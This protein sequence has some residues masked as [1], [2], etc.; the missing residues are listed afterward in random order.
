MFLEGMMGVIGV[1]FIVLIRREEG[2]VSCRGER[3]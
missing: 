2:G 3:S 1:I